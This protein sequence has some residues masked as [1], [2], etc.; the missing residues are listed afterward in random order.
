MFCIVKAKHWESV[1]RD[2][3]ASE[4]VALMCPETQRRSPAPHGTAME[5]QSKEP[6]RT[7]MQGRSSAE[8]SK[9]A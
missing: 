8:L 3:W 2:G 4:R 5:W 1:T 6:T 7:E 9:V